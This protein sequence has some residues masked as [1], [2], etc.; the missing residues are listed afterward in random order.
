MKKK[1]DKEVIIV[2]Y[3]QL[4]GREKMQYLIIASFAKAGASQSGNP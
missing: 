2:L 3:K 1:S 4:F